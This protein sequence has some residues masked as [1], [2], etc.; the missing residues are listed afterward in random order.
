MQENKTSVH[1]INVEYEVTLTIVLGVKSLREQGMLWSCSHVQGCNSQFFLQ[2][3]K[4]NFFIF[5]FQITLKVLNMMASKLL[6]VERTVL[7]V[8]TQ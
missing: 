4:L 2:F 6:L 1:V 5:F 7:E 8:Q 3:I